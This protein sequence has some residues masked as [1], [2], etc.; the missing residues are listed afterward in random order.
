MVLAVSAA[1]D[2]DRNDDTGDAID[3]VA[4]VGDLM[5]CPGCIGICTC[6]CTGGCC[7]CV[8]TCCACCCCACCCALSLTGLYL[9]LFLKSCGHVLL[10]GPR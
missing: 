8:C 5:A 4:I 9:L 7:C 6:C 3:C 1:M 2:G 10:N